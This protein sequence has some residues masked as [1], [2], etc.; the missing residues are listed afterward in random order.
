MQFWDL[1][2]KKEGKILECPE[3]DNRIGEM[4]GGS[5][6]GRV[7]KDSGF[8]YFGKKEVEG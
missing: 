5:I 8:V 7:A 6:L 2:F 1:Q 3:K 4:A